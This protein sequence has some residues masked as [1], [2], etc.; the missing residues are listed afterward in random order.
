MLQKCNFNRKN[1]DIIGYALFKLPFE[2][3]LDLED[4]E[5]QLKEDLNSNRESRLVNI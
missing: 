4:F 1:E 3:V 2:N 5:F